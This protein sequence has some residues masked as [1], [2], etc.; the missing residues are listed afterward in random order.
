MAIHAVNEKDVQMAKSG[1]GF[2][3]WLHVAKAGRDRK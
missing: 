2:T 3:K 1:R